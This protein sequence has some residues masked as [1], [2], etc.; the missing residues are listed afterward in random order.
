MKNNFD[1]NPDLFKNVVNSWKKFADDA[2]DAFRYMTD[3]DML[4]MTIKI[5]EW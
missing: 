3:Q 1:I 5:L 4:N 2:V